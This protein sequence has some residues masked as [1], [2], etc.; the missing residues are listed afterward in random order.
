[1]TATETTC[2]A[3]RVTAVTHY[4]QTLTIV[5]SGATPH[6]VLALIISLRFHL[7]GNL[8]LDNRPTINTYR[9]GQ[10][11]VHKRHWCGRTSPKKTPAHALARVVCQ[12]KAGFCNISLHPLPVVTHSRH[13]NHSTKKTQHMSR[14]SPTARQISMPLFVT[15]LD[16]ISYPLPPYLRL[17]TRYSRVRTG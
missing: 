8:S 12:P 9:I 3:S 1:M 2:H 17:V 7:S 5:N 15:H 13:S 11:I 6:R 10:G 16:H 14:Q 4:Y